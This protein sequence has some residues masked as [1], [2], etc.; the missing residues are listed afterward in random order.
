VIPTLFAAL[1]ALIGRREDHRRVWTLL[2]VDRHVPDPDVEAH[3]LDRTLEG[4]AHPARS[5]P[6]R[7]G[8]RHTAV[9]GS[10]RSRPGQPTAVVLASEAGGPVDPLNLAHDLV[11][12][13]VG[14]MS[15]GERNRG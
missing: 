8:G 12:S 14:R 3:R 7:P 4:A 2:G 5:H 6:P 9:P 11:M 15:K 13:V 10:R 1:D